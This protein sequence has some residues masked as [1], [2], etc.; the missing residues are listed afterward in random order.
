[1]GILKSAKN[2][3]SFCISITGIIKHVKNLE[4]SHLDHADFRRGSGGNIK[5]RKKKT[6]SFGILTTPIPIE[7]RIPDRR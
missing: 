5:K 6:L 7:G 3:S 1:M 4:F 2:T